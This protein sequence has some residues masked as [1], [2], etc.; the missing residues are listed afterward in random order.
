MI[1]GWEVQGPRCSGSRDGEGLGGGPGGPLHLNNQSGGLH[2]RRAFPTSRLL[3]AAIAGSTFMTTYPPT[4]PAPKP[5][6]KTRSR[7]L[8]T[9]LRMASWSAMGIDADEVLATVSML[10]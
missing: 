6:A 7:R 5:G 10:K 3:H 9:P 8:M 1:N 4:A 2:H